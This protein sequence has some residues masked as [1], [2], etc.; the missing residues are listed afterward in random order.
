M[1]KIYEVIIVIAAMIFVSLALWFNANSSITTPTNPKNTTNL[2]AYDNIKVSNS[3]I[4]ELKTIA[5]NNTLADNV[6]NGNVD[7]FP[8]T[9]SSSNQLIDNNKTEVLYIGAD[10]CPYCAAVRWGLI[11]AL[12][13]FGNFT[14]LSYMTSSATDVYPSTPT[15]TFYNSSYQSS[16]LA[17]VPV[18]IATNTG[19]PL[20]NLTMSENKTIQKFGYQESIPFIDFG[21]QS[22]VNGATFTP[23][24]LDGENWSIIISQLE[25]SNS[26]IS[27]EII[28]SANIFTAQICRIDGGKPSNICDQSYVSI[29]SKA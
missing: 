19:K 22:V 16:Y 6:G 12:L 18:E 21:N 17:F 26:T 7:S 29:A 24:A 28:G 8:Q 20:E 9:I 2:T 23:Q 11:I 4:A 27:K 10:Y 1:K 5:L 25:N 13:R 3:V 14:N 15:F